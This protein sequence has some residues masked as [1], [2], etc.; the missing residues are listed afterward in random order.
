MST[1][2]EALAP[3]PLDIDEGHTEVASVEGIAALHEADQ[4]GSRAL[5]CFA[6]HDVIRRSRVGRPFRLSMEGGDLSL[7][8]S[9]R[10][11]L[12]ANHEHHLDAI[13]GVVE[14]AWIDASLGSA[15]AI[16]RFAPTRRG[17]DAQA[18]VGA[19][20][21]NNCSMGFTMS[22]DDGEDPASVQAIPWWRPYEITLCAL[23]AN[24]HGHVKAAAPKTLDRL[25]AEESAR[26]AK[27][28]R[29]AIAAD[30]LRDA[31]DI[32]RAVAPD[33]AQRL[34]IEPGVA[35]A[36]LEAA[37]GAHPGR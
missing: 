25:A 4:S 16:A 29:D 34:G 30:R 19:G 27:A 35:G 21:L 37:I 24:W 33:L 12:L 23:P 11:P 3:E 13:L 6:S 18:M 8:N 36:A 32:G 22:A 20:V 28:M 5:L 2:M 10:A 7:L 15:F 31:Q 14:M 17:L 9:G 1:T 26:K